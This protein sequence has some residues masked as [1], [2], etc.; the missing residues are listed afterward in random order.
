M[1]NSRI[2][3]QKVFFSKTDIMSSIGGLGKELEFLI[4]D[5]VK[6]KV[7]FKKGRQKFRDVDV[8]LIY[9]DMYPLKSD[10]EIKQM[11]QY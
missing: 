4:S 10:L 2:K 1:K 9:K 5:T 7:G 6:Q 11:I 8:F 3:R